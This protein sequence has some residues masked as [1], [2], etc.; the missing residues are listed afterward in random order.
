MVVFFRLWE[1]TCFL[2]LYLLPS[3]FSNCSTMKLEWL[4]IPSRLVFMPHPCAPSHIG[5]QLFPWPIEHNG[6]DVMQLVRLSY[7]RHCG[8]YLGLFLCS[9]ALGEATHYCVSSRIR[10][11]SG[12]KWR[13]LTMATQVTL[14]VAQPPAQLGL[15]VMHL[16]VTVT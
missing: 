11:P 8:F 6:S 3:V 13:L 5:P 1:C 2:F 12:G 9:P 4:M 10:R 14:T 7:K 15:Q 16:W